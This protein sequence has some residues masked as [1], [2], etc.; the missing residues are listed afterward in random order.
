MKLY[1]IFLAGCLCLTT[2]CSDFLDQPLTNSVSDDNIGEI[3]QR[4]PA[5]LGDFLAGSY[6]ALGG[7]HLY[8][9]QTEYMATMSHE[10]DID[11]LGEEQRNQ[12]ATNNLTST[13][14][15][16]QEAY[17]KYYKALSSAN[18]MLDL[19]DHVNLNELNDTERELVKNFK[20]EG[21]FLRAFIHFDLLRIFGEKGPWFGGDYPNNKDAQGIIL[22]DGLAD[23]NSA[24]KARASVEKCYASIL[25]DLKEAES[26]IGNNQI[27]VNT[28]QLVPGY[29]DDDYTKDYGWAQLPAVRALLGKVYLYMNDL[30][31]AKIKFEE[32]LADSRFSLDRPVNFTDHIQHIDNN[33]EC[34]FSLQYY[35]FSKGSAY[36]DSPEH[37]L[38]RIFGGAPGSWKNYF[39]DQRTAARFGN[40]P[41]LYEATLYDYDIDKWSTA[42]EAVVFKKV[43]PTVEDFRYYQRKYTDFYKTSNQVFSNKNVD[44]IRLGDVYLMYAEVMLKKGS[45]DVAKEYVNKLRRRAWDEKDYNAP[46]TK[47]E[48]LTAISMEVIQEERYKELFFENTRWYDLC[49]WGILEQELAKY[50][51]TKAGAVHYDPQDYYVPIPESELRSNPLMKQ[52]KGY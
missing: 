2:S 24:I 39:V 36:N 43:D 16:V 27:P 6:R 47:G 5:K 8:G 48:D 35:L 22:M 17:D 7:I 15:N 14:K 28:R 13:N 50:P 52:S 18:L 9:R 11:W 19:I 46:G 4:N 40:D 42:T 37:H 29:Q 38:V 26:C 49:R 23:A 3:I 20:G 25:G 44:I 30:D 45:T 1:H 34:I 10:M 41:R 32:V 21:L 31:N 12:W 51:T 33:P